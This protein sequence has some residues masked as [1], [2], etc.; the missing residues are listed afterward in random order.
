MDYDLDGICSVV[1]CNNGL[2]TNCCIL[3]RNVQAKD[4]NEAAE[5]AG[6]AVV[7]S[8]PYLEGLKYPML[9]AGI[10]F[11][12]GLLYIKEKKGGVE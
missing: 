2:W 7:N 9:I 1:I 6:Q 11:V 5:K 12:I 10:C 3:G 8:Q 4:A